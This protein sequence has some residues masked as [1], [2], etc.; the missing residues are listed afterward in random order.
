MQREYEPPIREFVDLLL[1]QFGDRVIS[2]LVFGPIALGWS[3]HFG[4]GQFVAIE[5]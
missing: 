2:M 5:K 1:A 3:S 4:L